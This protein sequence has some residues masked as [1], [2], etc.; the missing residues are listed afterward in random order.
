MSKSG[1]QNNSVVLLLASAT[2]D[3]FF[4]EFCDTKVLLVSSAESLYHRLSLLSQYEC[5]T[6]VSGVVE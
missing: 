4:R 2:V 6:S 1:L 5:Y 3:N